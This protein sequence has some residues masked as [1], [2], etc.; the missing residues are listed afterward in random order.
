MWG[1]RQWVMATV[2][3]LAGLAVAGQAQE[4]P[5]APA[6]PT[7]WREGGLWIA[8]REAAGALGFQVQYQSEGGTVEA[9]RAG[10]EAAASADDGGAWRSADDRLFVPVRFLEELGYAVRW[11][12][13]ANQAVVTW[14]DETAVLTRHPKS[15]A[16]NLNRQVLSAREGDVL[17]YRFRVSTGKLGHR[18]PNGDYRV[19]SKERLHLSRTYNNARMP[20]SLRFHGGYFIHGFAVVPRHPASHGCIRLPIPEAKMLYAWTPMGTPVSIYRSAAQD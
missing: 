18:T 11:E 12:A 5:S 7:V 1:R 20:Y 17:V 6:V 2:L 9:T 15:I 16:V 4:P 14:D 3:A 10:R 19:L 8:V 13:E